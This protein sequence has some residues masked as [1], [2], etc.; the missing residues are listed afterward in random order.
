ME[1]GGKA[2]DGVMDAADEAKDA[3]ETTVKDVEKAME[4]LK[5][6]VGKTGLPA[7]ECNS[8]NTAGNV[9]LTVTGDKGDS[10]RISLKCGGTVV[11]SCQADVAADNT[12]ASCTASGTVPNGGARSC[13]VGPGNGNS[14]NAKVVT[15]GCG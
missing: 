8:S 10:F 13:S 9:S 6:D 1:E 11:A 5:L 12:P 14:N 2:I 7:L 15:S 4:G 3:A